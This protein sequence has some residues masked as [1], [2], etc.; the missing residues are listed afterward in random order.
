[1]RTGGAPMIK[2]KDFTLA[3]KNLWGTCPPALRRGRPGL[4]Q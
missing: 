1:M 2:I 3:S 4:G